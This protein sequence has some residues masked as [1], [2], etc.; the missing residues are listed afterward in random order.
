VF[1]ELTACSPVHHGEW[2]SKCREESPKVTGANSG[3]RSDSLPSSSSYRL[4]LLLLFIYLWN[5]TKCDVDDRICLRIKWTLELKFHKG[6]DF[7][8]LYSVNNL[9]RLDSWHCK[10]IVSAH[11]IQPATETRVLN[12]RPNSWASTYQVQ[13]VTTICQIKRPGEGTERRFII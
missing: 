12:P 6:R 5:K 8:L 1:A 4:S 7:Y 2:H 10:Q 11:Q 3:V 13:P 9:Y